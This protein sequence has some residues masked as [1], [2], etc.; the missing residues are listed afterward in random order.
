MELLSRGQRLVDDPLNQFNGTV[1]LGVDQLLELR[2][3]HG[4]DPLVPARADTDGSRP[5]EA[6]GMLGFPHLVLQRGFVGA[7]TL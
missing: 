3:G 2:A 1:N 5:V 7:G 4:A 6:Q